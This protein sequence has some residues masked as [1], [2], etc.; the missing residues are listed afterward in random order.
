MSKIALITGA[1][2]GIGAATSHLLAANGFD[3]ILTGRRN[4]RL[5]EL[6]HELA[7][8]YKAKCLLLCFDVTKPEQVQSSLE[9]LTE[10]WKAVDV[11]I[12]NA[13]LAVGMDTVD[14]GE[15]EDWERM[16]DTNVK[17]L[18]YVTRTVTPWMKKRKSGHIINISSLA[19]K[20]AYPMGGVYCG[21]KHAVQAISHAMRIELLPFG[22]KVGTVAPGMVDTEFSHVRF[23]G[24]DTRAKSVY[25]GL[26]PLSPIDVA[27]TILFLITR[28]AHVNIDDVLIMPTAQGSA[29]DVFR[30]Q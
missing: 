1:T 7:S 11:L 6:E 16:I 10:N 15:I 28:P 25:N 14:N 9:S 26:T 17:G 13:G 20:E 30:N 18:L 8:K 21:T 24:D 2:S 29:R 23:K 19:G 22:I 4:K 5:V 27:E 3:L 12:N